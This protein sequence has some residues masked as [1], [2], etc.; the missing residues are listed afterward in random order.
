[1]LWRAFGFV[2]NNYRA[3]FVEWFRTKEVVKALEH[4][5][6]Q[7]L[8]ITPVNQWEVLKRQQSHEIIAA[9]EGKFPIV[10]RRS[11]AYPSLPESLQRLHQPIMKASPY[12][13][14]RFS[15]T[16]IPRRAINLIKNAILSLRWKVVVSKDKDK[17]AEREKRVEIATYNLEHPNNYDS[18]KTL[19]E[20]VLEDFLVIGA[21]TIEPALTPA[22]KRPFK[23]WSVD[24]GTIGIFGDWEESKPQAAKYAQMTA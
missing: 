8:S 3:K 23:L 21:G 14:R 2:Y 19:M 11:W 16:P 7:E 5:H 20:P 1:M 17:N 9:K 6:L 24:S 22:Y 10:D 18:W 4:K 12:N 13:L 15:E